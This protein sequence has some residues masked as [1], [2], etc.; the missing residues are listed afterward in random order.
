MNR[1]ITEVTEK[2]SIQKQ[3]VK[4][5]NFNQEIENIQPEKD[6]ENRKNVMP[7]RKIIAKNNNKGLKTM[8]KDLEISSRSIANFNTQ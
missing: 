8:N 3:S 2:P 6:S 4:I 5:I 7:Q 1:V